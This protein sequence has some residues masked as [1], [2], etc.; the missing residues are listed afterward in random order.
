MPSQQLLTSAA[1][2]AS[3]SASTTLE[4]SSDL[5]VYAA[6][7]MRLVRRA[8]DLP[9]SV[10]V[11]TILDAIGPLGI[12]DLA[13]ADGCSQPTMSAQIAQLVETGLVTKEPNPADAR[14]SLVALTDAGRAD[15]ADVRERISHLI[16]ERLESHHRTRADLEAAVS[17]LRDLVEGESL[18]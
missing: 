8:L 14:A 4:L 13:R 11:L 16:A 7:L 18:A 15:L 3:G 9:A 17:V 6:R 2:T 1:P 5:V 10:R 12:T